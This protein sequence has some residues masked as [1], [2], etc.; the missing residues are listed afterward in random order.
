MCVVAH[1]AELPCG[2]LAREPS[3]TLRDAMTAIELM[4]PKMDAGMDFL[5]ASKRIR[6]FGESVSVCHVARCLIAAWS[7]SRPD[8][9][10]GACRHL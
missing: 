5:E 3:L 6:S 4:D 1:V 8:C 7:S 10:L 2:A 9:T